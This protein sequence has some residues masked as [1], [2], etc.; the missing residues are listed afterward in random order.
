[1]RW[2]LPRVVDAVGAQASIGVEQHG[3][4]DLVRVA[5]LGL[6]PQ[7]PARCEPVC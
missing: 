3:G 7:A 6:L 5:L 2:L 1:M 4:L